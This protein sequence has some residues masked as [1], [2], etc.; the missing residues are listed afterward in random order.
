MAAGAAD[1]PFII[2]LLVAGE[3]GVL[4]LLEGFFNFGIIE[5][6]GS[7]QDELLAGFRR[8]IE[9]HAV[10]REPLGVPGNDRQPLEPAGM[11]SKHR[12][13]GLTQIVENLAFECFE[14]DIHRRYSFLNAH[15]V[16][17]SETRI[18]PGARAKNARLS[19]ADGH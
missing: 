14:V 16:A 15:H 17:R 2:A 13:V 3:L 11:A 1:A 12:E 9:E 5:L 4:E 18:A 10:I 8:D 7:E 19:A 6:A